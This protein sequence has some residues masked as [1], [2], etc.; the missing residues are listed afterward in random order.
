MTFFAAIVVHLEGSCN[1]FLACKW[2]QG[3]GFSL[4]LSFLHF[5][6]DSSMTNRGLSLD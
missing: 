4:M 2:G 1:V 3:F 6:I 5:R